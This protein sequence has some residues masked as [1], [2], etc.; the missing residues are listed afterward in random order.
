MGGGTGTGAAPV[1]AKIAKN[2]GILTIGVVTKPF[3][4]EAQ[5]RMLNAS[6]GIDTLKEN[7]DTLIVI[8]ND[9]LLE[10]VDRRTTMPAALKKADEV[11]QQ[12]IQGITDLIAVPALINLDFADVST[13]MKDKGFA[14]VG[15]GTAKGNDKAMEAVKMAVASPLLETTIR[16]ASNVIVN[17]S[18]DVTLMDANDAV[19]HIQELAGEDSNIIFGT[20]YD[21]SMS[22]EVTITVIA[23]GL[24]PIGARA[25]KTVFA[26]TNVAATPNLDNNHV[27]EATKVNTPEPTRQE[28]HVK[29]VQLTI[30]DFLRKNR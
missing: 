29:E 10:I 19:T 24:E 4:F 12:A 26:K 5:Q 11:L 9:K 14:H 20:K 2:M 1:V 28:Y 25:T 8:S 17:I 16:G 18:G 27:M 6:N 22:D 7:V 30:P 15:I 13:V 21:E 23:T 3:K